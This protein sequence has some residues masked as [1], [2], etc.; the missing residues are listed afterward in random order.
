MVQSTGPQSAPNRRPRVA[1]YDTPKVMGRKLSDAL[2]R[3]GCDV[4]YDGPME[5]GT[6][7]NDA[8]IWVAKWTFLFNR[9]FLGSHHPSKGIITV[10]VGTDHI[11]MGAVKELGLRVENCPTFSSNSVAEHALALAVRGVYPGSALAGLEHGQVIF[12]RYSDDFAEAAVAQMLLRE[13]QLESSIL[14]ARNY[15]YFR[16]D[17]PRYRHDQP[18]NNGELGGARIGI[19]GRD[20]SAMRLAKTL[21]YG[22]N[23][24]I[25]GYDSSELLEA[26]GV[27]P[28]FIMELLDTC[29]YVFLCTERYG[30]QKASGLA[31]ADYPEAVK[32]IDT[33]TLALPELSLTRSSVAVL[34]TGS[35]GSII[36][37]MARMGFSSRVTAFN[38]S[39]KEDLLDIGV[40]YA[41]T[42][43]E[44]IREAN[45]IFIALPLNEG[46]RSLIGLESLSRLSL[47]P[48]VMVNVTRDKIVESEPLYGLLC[49]G[50]I[51]AYATDVL[52]NDA[53]LWKGGR[54]DDMTV[55]FVQHGAVIA[56]PH[57]GDCSRQSLGRLCNEVLIKIRDILG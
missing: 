56:T 30:L 7:R 41:A 42:V 10:S 33:Q 46:T 11:D 25:Y 44:A 55:R 45:F 24:D 52:P 14:R 31:G 35:I 12:T 19:V 28:M 54:P 22:F 9:D 5:A 36:A 16:K 50:G 21:R 26:Y 15:E 4:I 43:E 13:R 1:I 8:D 49:S 38:R 18:W 40:H 20:R 27:R 6:A 3:A 51:L 57:E 17:E 53:V 47:R 37:R 34:G 23:C 29:D 32:R 39:R 48:R 2:S